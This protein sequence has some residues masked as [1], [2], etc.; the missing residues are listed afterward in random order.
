MVPP[1]GLKTNRN[2]IFP[3]AVEDLQFPPISVSYIHFNIFVHNLIKSALWHSLDGLECFGEM[4]AFG[5]SK[6]SFRIC[7]L[8]VFVLRNHTIRQR[9]RHGYVASILDY[10]AQECAI[11]HFHILIIPYRPHYPV[12]KEAY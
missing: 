2:T 5:K 10:Q 7:S 12:I 1:K 9:Y 11:G 3:Q 8:C 4:Q 6:S